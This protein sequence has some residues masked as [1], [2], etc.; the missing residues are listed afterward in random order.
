[1]NPEQTHVR[2]QQKSLH[3]IEFMSKQIQ[4]LIDTYLITLL[5]VEELCGKNLA[6]N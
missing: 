5:T 4:P 2:I 3:L 6:V 1:M